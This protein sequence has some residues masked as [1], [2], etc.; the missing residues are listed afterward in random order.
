M[1]LNQR[2]ID[3]LK[4]KLSLIEEIKEVHEWLSRPLDESEYPALIIRDPLDKVHDDSLGVTEAHK[5]SIEI[6]LVISPDVYEA[7]TIRE[8]I[9]KVKGVI[10]DAI[11]QEDFFYYC[12]Y[13]G[14]EIVGEHRDY[15]Y[16]AS[17]LKF[18]INY[19]TEKWS[20]E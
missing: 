11:T 15:F 4:N 7:V 8:L 12:R 10:R 6:D 9:P 2:I 20:E 5:L 3:Q 18:E 14:R 17:R 13:L 16:I 1:S 19:E